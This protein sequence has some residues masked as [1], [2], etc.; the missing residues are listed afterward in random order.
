MKPFLEEFGYPLSEYIGRTLAEEQRSKY[1]LHRNYTWD[2]MP[3][4]DDTNYT[5]IGLAILERHGPGFT[6]VDVANFWMSNVPI[7]HTCTAERA[8]YR[9]LVNMIPPPDS[10]SHRNPY[11]EWIGAQI[12]A[13]AF[14]Y[15]CPGNP[16]LAA[17][18][19][20]RDACISHVKNGIYGEMFVAAML[21]AAFLTD[22]AET[23]VRAGMGEVPAKSR[24][25]A[26]VGRVLDWR[27]SGVSYEDAVEKIHGEWDE[28]RSHD[29]CHTISNA[30]T[31][32]VGLL[33]GEMDYEKS[34]TRAVM[35]CFDT[36]C[37]GATV[38]SI[39][40]AALGAARLPQ[41]WVGVLNDT[42]ET[43]VAGY[44]VVRLSEMATKTMGVIEAV[45][46]YRG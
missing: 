21:A 7:L 26:A 20:W 24:L 19:A 13:D 32:S 33:W 22:E 12:R 42:L 40:G 5:T 1:G 3:E 46:A 2:R 35:P 28:R 8:A 17:E 37:N 38:G 45:S 18:F 15:A 29:W 4:D 23:I 44:N 14:G 36:D 9:N 39:V 30:M 31:V 16:E 41:K 27:G 6:P 25:A 10:A 43:G 11:R 34:I